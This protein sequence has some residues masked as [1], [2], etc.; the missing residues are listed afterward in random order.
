MQWK[1]GILCCVL[2][3][4]NELRKLC[5]FCF[6]ILGEL[7]WFWGFC[8]DVIYGLT[9]G[10]FGFITCTPPCLCAPNFHGHQYS[11]FSLSFFL[12]FFSLFLVYIYTIIFVVKKILKYVFEAKSWVNGIARMSIFL[13]A[14]VLF[15]LYILILPINYL[16]AWQR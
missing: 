14:S 7:M 9:N 13:Y 3:N 2:R 16:V 10:V 4:E 1:S 8:L 6:I 15:N 5:V 12:S 11:Y